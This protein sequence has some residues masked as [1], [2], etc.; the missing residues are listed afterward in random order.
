MS[1]MEEGSDLAIVSDPGMRRVDAVRAFNRF[2]TRRI[3]VL[4]E[5]YLE[6]PFSLVQAR[7]LYELAHRSQPTAT[8]IARDLGLDTGYLSRILR[9]FERM[10]LVEKRPSARDGRRRL[11]SLTERGREAFAPLETRSRTETE[12]LLRNLSPAAQLRLIGAMGAITK[13]LDDETDGAAT[14]LLRPHRT[15]DMGWVVQ[16][17]GLL[18]AEEYGW[19]ETFEALVAE[20]VAGFIRHFDPERERCW[21]VERDGENV[22]S[23]FLV[24]HPEREGVGQLRLLLV[25]PSARGLGLGR[26]LVDECTRFARQVGYHT[27]TL[28]TNDVL[29]SARRIYEV[30]GFHLVQEERHQ[31][32]GQDL[33]GQTWELRVMG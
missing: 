16:Q 25:E 31:S 22:G 14:Y 5:G 12:E 13:L 8:E 29:V 3:G 19:D 18:Y 27:V 9:G 6:S 21:I 17:H 30:V 26:R 33:V 2:Y 1:I 32:F 24:A 7:V 23:V 4:E 11:L 15:G 20:I 10:G 28:W